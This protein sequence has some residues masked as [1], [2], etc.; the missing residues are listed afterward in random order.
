MSQARGTAN[1]SAASRE[2]DYWV[3]ASIEYDPSKFH[4]LPNGTFIQAK[5]TTAG[6][7]PFESWFQL[8]GGSKIFPTQMRIDYRP[9][10]QAISIFNATVSQ[11]LPA[12]F[13]NVPV[14]G[15]DKIIG[16]FGVS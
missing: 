1:N 4:D 16:K 3:N 12:L 15:R 8:T 2:S 7:T 9:T 5:V 13:P 14:Q 10:H 11:G 6:G